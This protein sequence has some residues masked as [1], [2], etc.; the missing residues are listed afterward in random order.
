[1]TDL[2]DE[3]RNL[4]KN[5]GRNTDKDKKKNEVEPIE[6]IDEQSEQ[7]NS[8]SEKKEEITEISSEK[9]DNNEVVEENSDEI[10]SENNN[11]TE[12]IIPDEIDVIASEKEETQEFSTVT[13]IENEVEEEPKQENENVLSE[14]SFEET[15]DTEKIKYCPEC[16]NE[17]LLDAV[18]CNKCGAKLIK[19]TKCPNCGA[20][21]A[22]ND[23][24]CSKC[25]QKVTNKNTA[26]T[27]L[28]NKTIANVSS[29]QND[30]DTDSVWLKVLLTLVSILL[31]VIFAVVI[32][33]YVVNNL[34]EVNMGPKAPNCEAE[35]VK[36]IAASIFKENNEIYKAMDPKSVVSIVLKYPSL[37]GY[38][39]SIDKYNCSGEIWVMSAES[40]FLPSSTENN[41][42]F[43]NRIAH[44]YSYYGED[45]YWDRYTKY[46]VPVEYTTQLS[47]GSTLV[48]MKQYTGQEKFSTTSGET[49]MPSRKPKR[50]RYE[51]FDDYSDY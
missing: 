49:T 51:N 3:M 21:I 50:I 43:Y 47:E 48:S 7:E 27:D 30:T 41:N 35:E 42:K 32:G 37:N 40:G 6:N 19:E 26:D 15:D 2:F 44:E 25:G 8:D 13:H 29:N 9:T 36:E 34:P 28:Y 4:V 31:F 33:I 22:K 14:N 5:F 24:F 45:W 38:D 1:M 46:V 16:G 39:E 11:V 23:V 17:C 10:S 20:E 18:F 12:E